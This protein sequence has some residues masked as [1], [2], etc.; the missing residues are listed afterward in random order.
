MLKQQL[1]LTPCP[2]VPFQS[3]TFYYSLAGYVRNGGGYMKTPTWQKLILGIDL[4]IDSYI[5]HSYII[6]NDSQWGGMRWHFFGWEWCFLVSLDWVSGSC[7]SDR[8]TKK[9]V[10]KNWILN[11]SFLALTPDCLS[12]LE[13]ADPT[14]CCNLFTYLRAFESNG[15]TVKICIWANLILEGRAIWQLDQR[16]CGPNNC[17]GS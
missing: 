1:N 11:E 10:K 2:W 6:C 12:E 17:G 4:L 9:I 16:Y 5:C 14:A 15:G 8:N 13:I 3:T 7:I